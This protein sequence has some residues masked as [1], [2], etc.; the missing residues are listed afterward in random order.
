M[1]TIIWPYF[2]AL[3]FLDCVLFVRG[4]HL[5]LTGTPAS[6]FRVRGPGLRLAGVLPW[7]WTVLSAREKPIMTQDGLYWRSDPNPDPFRPP[8]PDDLEFIP[9]E[10]TGDVITDGKRVTA[11]GKPVFL[12][13]TGVEAAACREEVLK[14]RDLPAADRA[15]AIEENLGA[16]SD[17]EPVSQAQIGEG[18]VP[19]IV[20][21]VDLS[22]EGGLVTG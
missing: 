3:Y 10:E 6:G 11:G 14:L 5:I 2:A 13:S 9:W 16:A 8:G 4:G 17:I 18:H 15:A 20:G 21:I 1:L 19:G 12:A 7:D 22:S